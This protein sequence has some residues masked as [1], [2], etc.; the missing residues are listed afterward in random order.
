MRR[1]LVLT[2]LTVS[3][4]GSAGAQGPEVAAD[5]P[6]SL[7]VPSPSSV[8]ESATPGKPQ[9]ARAIAELVLFNA[10][11]VGINHI[12]RDIPTAGL[13]QFATV[14]ARAPLPLGMAV[15]AAYTLYLQLSTYAERTATTVSLPALSLFVSTSGR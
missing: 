11:A 13:V 8:P 1:L 14:E 5:A 4:A 3:L 10:A 7:P 12:A 6:D 2:L 15:G 9:V